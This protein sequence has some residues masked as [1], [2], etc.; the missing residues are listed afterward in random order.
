MKLAAACAPARGARQRGVTY[1]ALLIAVAL[2]SGALA[3]GTVV[4]SH[5]QRRE[6]EVQLLWAGHEIRL[7]LQSYAAATPEGQ[8]AHPL[9]LEDLLDDARSPVPRH[10][11]RRV[12]HDPMN[13]GQPWGL[14]RD[15]RGG[16]VGVYSR[17][18]GQP[19]R[20]AG[21]LPEYRAFR[22]ARSYRDWRFALGGVAIADD[23]AAAAGAPLGT[24]RTD[25]PVPGA[26]EARAADAA[27][28]AA[29]D[30]GDEER[31]GTDPANAEGSATNDA[32]AT[33]AVEPA[34][35]PTRRGSP[36]GSPR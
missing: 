11:L 19:I 29:S 17:A 35:E 1:L 20:T 14:L 31:D 27:E 3:A 36:P 26:P 32:E 2:T 4:W 5:Q 16:I 9:R 30:A 33:D 10:H 28:D 8:A 34:D 15:E 7:A 25:R 13:H 24:R 21:F 18:E 12:Y 22:K 23:D 6:R